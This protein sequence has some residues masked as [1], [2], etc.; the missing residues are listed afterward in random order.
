MTRWF[1]AL[2]VLKMV[3]IA[4]RS[5]AQG[6]G[7]PLGEDKTVEF[8]VRRWRPDLVSELRFGA[9]ATDIDPVDDFGSEQKESFEFRLMVRMVRTV[10]LRINWV[11]PTFTGV[12]ALGHDITAGDV[13]IPQ[14]TN[15]A[16]EIKMTD[17]N[18]GIELDLWASKDGFFAII[19]QFSRFDAELQFEGEDTPT[20]VTDQ[21][22]V[23]LPTFGARAR[24]NLTPSFY[25]TTEWAGMKR[26][27]RGVISDFDVNVAFS[28]GP[29]FF[30]EY[31]Y[32]N[33]YVRD[34]TVEEDGGRA[35]FRLRG[36]YFGVGVRF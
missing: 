15:L 7:Q 28:A 13:T 26:D 22:R 16:T 17:L 27:S 21:L 33:L 34:Y 12:K 35:V 10:K 23:E 11:E 24:L 2:F 8:E 20:L 9:G 6:R 4:G 30:F 18:V 3:L 29:M 19:G 31:G 14:G 5:W 32:R 36:Q 25:V 1:V